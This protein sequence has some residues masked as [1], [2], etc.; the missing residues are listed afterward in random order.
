MACALPVVA[1][2]TPVNRELLGDAGLYAPVG[3]TTALADRLVELLQSPDRQRA[4]GQAL[5]QRVEREFGWPALT[6]RLIELYG[7]LVIT[8]AR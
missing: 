6:D 3:D 1:T 4:L 2:D 5:H 8:A 7:Q